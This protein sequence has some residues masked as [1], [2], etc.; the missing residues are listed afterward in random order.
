MD[1][2]TL[3]LEPSS[4]GAASAAALATMLK[5]LSHAGESAAGVPINSCETGSHEEPCPGLWDTLR[6]TT[7][8]TLLL[9]FVI[10]IAVIFLVAL[11]LTRGTKT[12]TWQW[13]RGK[14]RQPSAGHRRIQ[15]QW[16]VRLETWH[17]R[18][19]QQCGLERNRRPL[20]RGALART[21]GV[22]KFR[23][24]RLRRRCGL[25]GNFFDPIRAS[26][27]RGHPAVRD[28]FLS[29]M[30]S[31]SSPSPVDA[32]ADAVRHISR[33]GQDEAYHPCVVV[34]ESG[35]VRGYDRDV[36]RNPL[37]FARVFDSSRYYRIRV[38]RT[39]ICPGT[40]CLFLI[41]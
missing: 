31:Y 2:F 11:L 24:R 6:G 19:I 28:D 23:H 27:A 20:E 15:T 36:F 9:A 30:E 7:G 39:G 33:P 13:R 41:G 32:A 8:P 37:Q 38:N 21:E 35:I 14:G 26:C 17:P 3:G 5:K 12:A 25:L 22:F 40:K 16:R 18:P 29:F 1:L 4:G 34:V 10:A